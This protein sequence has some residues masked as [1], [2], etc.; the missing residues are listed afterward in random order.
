MQTKLLQFFSRIYRLVSRHWLTVA[1]LA[2]FVTDLILLDEI[3]DVFDNIVMLVYVVLATFSLILFYVAVAERGPRWLTERLYR[4]TPIVMQYAFGGLL[5]SMLIFYGRS[6]DLVASA[7]FLMLIV[8]AIV[9]NELVTKKS[10]RLLYNLSLYFIGIL[11]YTV[12]VVPV[13]LGR[14]GDGVF[15]AS[16]ILAVVLTMLV[17]KVLKFI[18]PNFLTMQKRSIV[19]AVGSLYVVFNTLYFFNM[20]PPIP[21]SLTQ[22]EIYH[23]VE[24]L[25]TGDYQ[26]VRETKSWLETIPWYP[27]TINLDAS[28]SLACFARVYAPTDLTTMIRHQWSWQNAAG[29]WE[30]RA[31]ISYQI[32]GGNEAGYRGFTVITNV[33]PGVWRCSV[34]NARGQVLGR[35]TFTVVSQPPPTLVTV[36]E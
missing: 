15:I 17:I 14:T 35:Q 28:R 7:P 2:G 26:I 11:S 9:I 18:I 30:K 36:V 10:E 27:L 29:E 13:F 16:G 22:L 20:I 12:L 34:E 24:K 3:D 4:V 6:G 8:G 21:L 31:P 1:F 25:P 23:R 19:F 5:S 33:T 32:F